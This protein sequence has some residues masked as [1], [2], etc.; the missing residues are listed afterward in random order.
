MT[1]N[2]IENVKAALK[3][4]N[5][6]LITAWTVCTVVLYWMKRQELHKLFI[7]KIVSKTLEKEYMK[8]YYVP[9]KQNPAETGS[10]GNLLSKIPDI[11]SKGPLCRVENNK[12]LD[13]LI[14]SGS[15][16]SEKRS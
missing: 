12:W 7:A 13:Q 6:R 5:I 2:L 4:C 11:W 9:T 10:R 8:R 15:K 3:C 14:L 16:E 1:S